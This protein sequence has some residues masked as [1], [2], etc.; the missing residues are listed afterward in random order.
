MWACFVPSA[1]ILLGPVCCTTIYT[2]L[3]CTHCAWSSCNP[4]KNKTTFLLT[5]LDTHITAWVHTLCLAR[6]FYKFG[7]LISTISYKLVGCDIT[8]NILIYL[9]YCS[10]KINWI[11]KHMNTNAV[12][13]VTVRDLVLT[14]SSSCSWWN[15]YQFNSLN[16]QNP[17]HGSKVRGYGCK[18]LQ[19]LK[20]QI[21]VH[22]ISLYPSES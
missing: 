15:S 4:K 1:N 8:V 2:C 13:Q 11:K 18:L 17:L 9:Q 10:S 14:F 5:S 20:W 21:S 7:S 6:I 16:F 19:W 22:L 3:W 12:I